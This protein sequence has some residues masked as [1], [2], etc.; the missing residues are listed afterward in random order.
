[1][2]ASKNKK[3]NIPKIFTLLLIVG[4]VISLAVYI[5]C[6]KIQVSNYQADLTRFYT[7][8][9]TLEGKLPGEIIRSQPVDISLPRAKVYRFLYV[10]QLFSGIK[11]YSSALIFIPSASP[12]PGG[13]KIVAWAHGTLGMGATCAPSRNPNF[14]DN[15][16]WITQMIQHNY[17]VVATDYSG[18]GTP[19]TERYLLGNDQGL[20]VLYS[21]KAANNY[22]L[23]QTSHQYALWGHS[24]GGQAVLFASRL[25]DKYLPDFQLISVSAAAPAAELI[26]LLKQQLN[27]PIPWI[28]ASQI[29]VSWPLQY[30]NLNLETSLTPAANRNYYQTAMQCITTS[31]IEGI[32]RTKIGQNFF[33]SDP[34]QNPYWRQAFIDQTATP[35]SPEVPL[36][37]IQSLSD[38]VVLPNTTSLFITKSCQH[39][40]R[41]QTM[42]LKNVTHQD[43]VISAG[44]AVASWINDRFAGRT[45][46]SNCQDNLPVPPV[47]EP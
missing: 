47:T 6:Q 13:R 28:I 9:V 10:S 46:D 44:P 25:A 23:S 41:L 21:V 8:P 31:T 33:T 42:W 22:T 2:A 19:G 4:L 11:T 15:I 36:L 38:Q 29:A 39:N 16:P 43:T 3:P 26:P 5:Y 1:M 20:D 34:T 14:L 45:F 18:L 24:Q 12:P 37:I 7:S 40:P 35:I 30:S 27:T 17:V 32:I